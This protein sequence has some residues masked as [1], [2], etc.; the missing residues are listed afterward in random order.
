[1]GLVLGTIAFAKSLKPRH[2]LAI[3]M[4]FCWFI[5]ALVSCLLYV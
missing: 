2:P 4:M 3:N 1:M 5:Y